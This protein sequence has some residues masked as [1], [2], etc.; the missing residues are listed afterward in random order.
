[1]ETVWKEIQI[2]E[3]I[4]V[5]TTNAIMLSNKRAPVPAVYGENEHLIDSPVWLQVGSALCCRSDR[6]WDGWMASPMQ[7]TW[8]WVRCG[9]WWWIGKPGVMQT[10]SDHKESDMT[11]FSRTELILINAF[12]TSWQSSFLCLSFIWIFTLE[13]L[14]E[15]IL[16]LFKIYSFPKHLTNCSTFLHWITQPWLTD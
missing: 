11:E 15:L 6:G 9:S 4:L 13:S 1:M 10:M 14:I 8:V 7:W 3:A 16:L 12:H 2:S 5:N